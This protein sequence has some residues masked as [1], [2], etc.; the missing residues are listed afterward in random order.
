[1][2]FRDRVIILGESGGALGPKTKT[3]SDHKLLKKESLT[4]AEELAREQQMHGVSEI[5]I[6]LLKRVKKDPKKFGKEF[7]Q[8][9]MPEGVFTE[10]ELDAISS[11]ELEHAK[12]VN[13][14]WWLEGKINKK[15]LDAVV[16]KLVALHGNP[17]PE[18]QVE[19]FLKALLATPSQ[20]LTGKTKE[21]V[22][23]LKELPGS[24]DEKVVDVLDAYGQ[25][26]TLNTRK[27][28]KLAARAGV[29]ARIAELNNRQEVSGSNRE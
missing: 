27:A 6:E 10:E 17:L 3:T 21:F 29:K 4:A 1:M 9:S 23:A 25:R 2:K 18:K 15:H 14:A 7:Y 11:A 13:A 8:G 16:D 28:R 5:A 22:A 26:A 24:V 12:I 20:A 19:A